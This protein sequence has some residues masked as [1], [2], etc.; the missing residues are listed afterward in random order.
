MDAPG[1]PAPAADGRVNGHGRLG[2]RPARVTSAVDA[3]PLPGQPAL[4]GGALAIGLLL[5][6]LQLWLLTV[7]LDLYLGGHG[8]EVSLVALVSG[9]IFAGGLIVL[10]VLRRR[11]RVRRPSGDEAAYAVGAWGSPPSGS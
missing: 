3:P 6:A 11:P 10:A 2:Q 8:D 5:L 4:V 1:R 7:A 9:A